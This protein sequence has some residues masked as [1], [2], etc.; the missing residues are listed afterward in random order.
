MNPSVL[1]TIRSPSATS[2]R[3]LAAF[4]L[5]R[6]F[7]ASNLRSNS[8]IASIHGSPTDV[9][10]MIV[11]RGGGMVRSTSK[12]D[13]GF[14]IFYAGNQHKLAMSPYLRRTLLLFNRL[15][16]S[17]LRSCR[18]DIWPDTADR[19]FWNVDRNDSSV[20]RRF[21]LVCCRQVSVMYH[22]V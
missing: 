16:M 20:S 13:S 10:R 18:S 3:S 7:N 5:P 21:T 12:L 4:T 1:T 15:S 8:W 19:S 14:S 17:L 22:Q 2:W 9:S 11:A 6:S